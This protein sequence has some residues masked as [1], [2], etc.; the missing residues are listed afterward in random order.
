MITYPSFVSCFEMDGVLF[1]VAM[2]LPAF[3]QQRSSSAA[4]IAEKLLSRCNTTATQ[5][6][7]TLSIHRTA[8]TTCPKSQWTPLKHTRNNTVSLTPFSQI[9]EEGDIQAHD[10]ALVSLLTKNYFTFQ[11]IWTNIRSQ[12]WGS[13]QIIQRCVY[14]YKCSPLRPT[15]FGG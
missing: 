10:K 15:S 8:D 14:L 7:A 4:M 13:S 3:A 5:H 12:I 2:A 1:R 9:R 11:W 6:R